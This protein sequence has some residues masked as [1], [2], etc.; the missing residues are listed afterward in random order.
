MAKGQGIRKRTDHEC[1]THRYFL[2]QK[3]PELQYISTMVSLP[4]NT[5]IYIYIHVYI[6]TQAYIRVCIYRR[7][8]PA[9]QIHLL[10]VNLLYCQ[11]QFTVWRLLLVGF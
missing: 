1:F 8:K 7:M 4:T 11:K 5:D 10:K 2:T 9:M 6:C 3:F